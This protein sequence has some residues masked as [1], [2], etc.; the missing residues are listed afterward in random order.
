MTIE[1]L[2]VVIS[3]E[4]SELKSGIKEATRQINSLSTSTKASLGTMEKMISKSTKRITNMFS[5]LAKTVKRLFSFAVLGKLGK[6][7][8]DLASDLVEVQNV[9]DVAFGDMARE[10]EFFAK[11]CA[12]VFGL[13]ELSAKRYSSELM[14]MAN[15]AGLAAKTGK[16]LSLQVTALAGDLASFYN[17]S[18]DEAFTALEGIFT[19]VIRPLRAYGVNLSVAT[20]EEYALAKGIKTKYSAMS[21]A[22]KIALRYNYVMEATAQAQGDFARTSDSWANQIRILTLRWKELLSFLGGVLKT[23]LLPII[24]ALNVIL[25]QL[26]AIFGSFS[27]NKNVE[28][29]TAS[30]GG[31]SDTLEEANESAKKLKKTIAGFDELEILNGNDDSGSGSGGIS[32]D[33]GFDLVEP[34]DFTEQKKEMSD[35]LKTLNDYITKLNETFVKYN[36]KAGEFGKTI[37][38]TINKMFDGIKWDNLGQTLG[39]GFNLIINF[40][41]NFREELDA[42][43]IGSSIATAINHM[44]DTIDWNNLTSAFILK[45]N[46]IFDGLKAFIDTLDTSQYGARITEFFKRCTEEIKFESIA[47]AI[48]TGINKAFG[49]ALEVVNSGVLVDFGVKILNAIND[50]IGQ[51]NW[52]TVGKTIGGAISQGFQALKESNFPYEL[53]KAI[54]EALEA[55][56]I[57]KIIKDFLSGIGG[58]IGDALSGL[59]GGEPN[60]E[61]WER[62]GTSLFTVG[63]AVALLGPSIITVIDLLGKMRLAFGDFSTKGLHLFDNIGKDIKGLFVIKNYDW[64]EALSGLNEGL[65]NALHKMAEDTIK[66]LY[67]INNPKE[68]IAKI[69]S[70]LGELKTN[71][72]TNLA[73]IL[74][75]IKSF[76]AQISGVL[77]HPLQSIGSLISKVWGII[78]ANPFTTLIAV[79]AAAVAAVIYFYNTNEDFRKQ[80][81]EVFGEI[82]ETVTDLWENHLKPFWEDSLKPFL[83]LLWE[84]IKTIVKDIMDV[85]KPL[86]TWLV[87]TL[88]ALVPIITNIIG[89]IMDVIGGLLKFITG[90]FTGDWKKAWEGI[91]QI[92][93]GV[94]DG[95]GTICKAALNV[96]ITVI[97]GALGGIA[98]TINVFIKGIN[99]VISLAGKV[100]GKTWNG[101]PTISSLKIPL[102][103][104]GGVV[105]QPTLAQVGDAGKGNPEI[106]APQKMLNEIIQNNNGEL[107]SAFIQ[108]GRQ[109]VSAIEDKDLDVSFSDADVLQSVRRGNN[110]YKKQTGKSAFA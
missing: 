107:V 56:D 69:G 90:V 89:N 91:K 101:I 88:G 24:N 39:N 59:F 47:S 58:A 17:T 70:G 35:I 48:S 76:G 85:V 98:S 31:M 15:S 27:K 14:A 102:L 13:S 82:K 103:A 67:F 73:G 23:V 108:V 28:E 72:T 25:A 10:A 2:K 77:A 20:L 40:I 86:A 32:G 57:T 11:K 79:L 12:E 51:I 16:T 65:S 96:V 18:T 62:L 6:D 9:V 19:G 36:N 66:A 54:R 109:I 75:P 78:A 99:K 87:D 95:L 45:F 8:L 94:W 81:Q 55:A 5:S 84:M 106:V 110:A 64:S 74:E 104:T 53:G 42:I 37:A 52:N 97:N 60:S 71:I 46:N 61:G 83:A 80:V 30:F 22:Q 4:T 92:F 21:E 29:T 50:T 1:E 68:L 7:A 63:A 26:N 100:A 33:L 3:A 38:S 49:A 43:L 105:Y 34:Y 41:K 44:F 93:K